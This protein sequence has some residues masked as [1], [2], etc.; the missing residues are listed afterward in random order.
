MPHEFAAYVSVSDLFLIQ[1]IMVILSKS[2]K[3]GKLESH[4]SLKFNMT[5]LLHVRQT[6]MT[7]L[8][9]AIYL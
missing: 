7:K 4:N 6:R 9:L 5:F 8:I 3:P 2:C 1:L